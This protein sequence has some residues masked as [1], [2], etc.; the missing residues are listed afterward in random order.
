MTAR[1][2]DFTSG[3][4]YTNCF[5]VPSRSSLEYMR[6]LGKVNATQVIGSSVGVVST[7]CGI[8]CRRLSCQYFT[9][10]DMGNPPVCTLYGYQPTT[11]I[12]KA[13]PTITLWTDK[14]KRY[15]QNQ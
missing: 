7:M 2:Q 5:L 4:L 14:G 8:Y 11:G 9:T 13:D 15:T 6:Q 1:D 12:I 3:R 10:T